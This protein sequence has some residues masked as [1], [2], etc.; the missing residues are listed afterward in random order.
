MSTDE[1]AQCL[2]PKGRISG[3]GQTCKR[4][5]PQVEKLERRRLNVER[6]KVERLNVGRKPLGI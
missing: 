3:I 5:R 4:R 2:S 1:R 6:Q